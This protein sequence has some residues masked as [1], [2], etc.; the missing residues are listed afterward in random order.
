M[1]MKINIGSSVKTSEGD[2]IGHVERVILNPDSKEVDGLVVHRGLILTRDVIVPLSLVQSADQS[3]VHL[4]VGKDRLY[5]LPDF[6]ERHYAARPGES[7]VVYPYTPGSILFP[8]SP[9]YGVAGLPANY[10]PVAEGT[11]E[12][13]GDVEVS[14]GTEVRAVDGTIGTVDEVRTDPEADRVTAF[15]V[16]RGFGLKR[17][18]V[19]PIE[20]VDQ[21]ADNYIRLSLTIEQVEHL[22]VP[23]TDRYITRDK[24]KRTKPRKQK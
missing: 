22:P 14:E 6:V 17:D 4:R 11:Q 3:G 23:I 8:L 18:V 12:P 16:R 24:P 9:T 2:E 15:S 5:E 20:F 1:V 7:S 21:V 13:S 10:Q 19:I